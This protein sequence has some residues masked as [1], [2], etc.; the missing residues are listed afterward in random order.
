MLLLQCSM[1]IPRIRYFRPLFSPTSIQY[2]SCMSPCPLFVPRHQESLIGARSTTLRFNTF[3]STSNKI[4]EDRR[5]YEKWETKFKEFKEFVQQH[6]HARVP[7]S[8]ESL[9]SWVNAS[10]KEYKKFVKD[11]K[12]CWMTPERVALLEEAGFVWNLDETKWMENYEKLCR[13][14]RDYG[15]V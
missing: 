12:P 11:Q 2:S 1:R 7:Q 8:H 5:Q 15:H 14:Y 6:G 13:Y 3:I 9:G 10:R 4:S